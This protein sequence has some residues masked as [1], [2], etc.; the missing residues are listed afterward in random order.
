MKKSLKHGTTPYYKGKGTPDNLDNMRHIHVKEEVPKLFSQIVIN[1]AKH[2]LV[3]N[4]SKFQIATKPG[5]RATEHVFVLLSIMASYEKNGKALIISMFD[6]SKYFDSESLI[7]CCAEIYRNK[8]KGKLYRLLF[9]LNKNVKIRVKTPVGVTKSH[10]TGP[11]VSQGSAEGAIISA[12]NLDNGVSEAFHDEEEN[13]EA[14]DKVKDDA[15]AENEVIQN[16]KYEEVVI[17]PMLF[18]DDV[19]NAA[20]SVEDAQKANRKMVDLLEKKLLNLNLDKSLCIIAG[21]KKAREKWRRK[22]YQ[23]Q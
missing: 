15:K 19:A 13:E 3:D 22:S 16:V 23:I 21:S 7:D 17:E 11:T 9:L 5:H 4:M 2:N 6:L 8:T 18:Q 14:T 12:D 20:D 1:A 10:D